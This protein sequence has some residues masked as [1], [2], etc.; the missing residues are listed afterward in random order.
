MDEPPIP[1]KD[2]DAGWRGDEHNLQLGAAA[3]AGLAADEISLDLFRQGFIGGLTIRDP[4]DHAMVLRGRTILDESQLKPSLRRIFA[5]LHLGANN[6]SVKVDDGEFE[7]RIADEVA[8]GAG[9]ATDAMRRALLVFV[10]SGLAGLFFFKTA[11]A[12][13]LLFWGVGLLVGSSIVRRGITKGRVQ[14]AA[15][16]VDE[17]ALLAHHEQL[18]LPPT[19]ASTGR[20][21]IGATSDD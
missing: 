13:S 5:H 2:N 15:R 7:L 8:Q 6:F 16:L 21:A 10:I 9:S 14:L 17:L 12:A 1:N 18:I 19:A 3:E 20:L 11:G 4:L